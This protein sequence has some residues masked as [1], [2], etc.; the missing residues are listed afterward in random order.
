MNKTYQRAR[1]LLFVILL[2]LCGAFATAEGTEPLATPAT[3]DA[4]APNDQ[5]DETAGKAQ[6]TVMIYLCGNYLL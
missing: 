6:W 5:T 1:A 2:A 3:A 4:V